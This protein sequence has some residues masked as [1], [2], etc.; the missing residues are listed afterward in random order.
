MISSLFPTELISPV[1]VGFSGAK[2]S[3]SLPAETQA[4]LRSDMM[5]RPNSQHRISPVE[6]AIIAIQASK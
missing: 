5:R 3:G 1:L 6:L 4:G 2:E